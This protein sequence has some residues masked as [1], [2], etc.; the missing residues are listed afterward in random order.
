MGVIVDVGIPTLGNSPFLAE[1]IE[2]VLAQTLSTWRLMISEI[3]RSTFDSK[4]RSRFV[5]MPTRRPSLLPSSVIG[6]P[7]MR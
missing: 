5:R 1:T 4:R 7:L 2:S 6:T 3:G